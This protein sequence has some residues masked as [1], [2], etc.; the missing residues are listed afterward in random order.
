MRFYSIGILIESG[1]SS[2][3][4]F[5][6]VLTVVWEELLPVLKSKMYLFSQPTL[7]LTNLTVLC[8]T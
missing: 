4:F 2:W 6:S 7:K 1:N 5:S 3:P 8:D